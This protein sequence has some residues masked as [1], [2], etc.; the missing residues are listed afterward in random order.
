MAAIDTL[1]VL[2]VGP[3]KRTSKLLRRRE[4][5]GTVE[6][7]GYGHA[8]YFRFSEVPFSDL[9]SFAH[10][11]DRIR[12]NPRAMIVRGA[13]TDYVRS[14]LQANPD[15]TFR[16]LSE[17]Q[18]VILRRLSIVPRRWCMADIDEYPLP[19]GA[20]LTHDAEE[21]IAALLPE[22]MPREFA[23]ASFVWQLKG[24]SALAGAICRLAALFCRTNPLHRRSDLRRA[25]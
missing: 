24:L 4:A 13:M 3:D 22:V 25:F 7:L 16:R 18:D 17:P 11:F 1:T 20:E 9:Q 19:P 5:D 10:A 15:Q 23:S 6:V 8:K 14:A 2:T 12:R 21:I